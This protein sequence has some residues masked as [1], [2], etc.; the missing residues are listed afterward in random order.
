M[1]T[2]RTRT[3]TLT[4]AA[5]ILAPLGAAAALLPARGHTENSNVALV[6]VVAVVAV[7][8]LGRRAA[9][10][11]AATSAML[12]F[13]FFYTQPYYSLRINAHDDLV[14]ALL[15]FCVGTVVGEL[16]IRNRRHRAAAA[17]GR[18][19]IARIHA[20]AELVAVGERPEHVV[21]EVANELVTLLSLR[22]CR[23]ERAP[24]TP[25]PSPAARI[26]RSGRV[27]IGRLTWGVEDMGMPGKRVEL[28]VQGYGRTFGRYVMVPTPALGISFDHRVVA[29]ALADQVGASF[30]AYSAMAGS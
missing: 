19:E 27:T 25:D 29:V 14:T 22:D 10:A 15:L 1:T 20:I 2:S 7:A 3:S 8:T 13:D 24:L 9:V 21:L 11:L 23:F 30:A 12:A 6:L 18:D 5:G 17:E 16:A 28:L 4:A 26:E